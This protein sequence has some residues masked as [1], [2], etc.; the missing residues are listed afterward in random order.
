[1]GDAPA[2][3]AEAR[4]ARATKSDSSIHRK[5]FYRAKNPA[6]KLFF[7]VILPRKIPVSSYTIFIIS[8]GHT[9]KGRNISRTAGIPSLFYREFFAERNCSPLARKKPAAVTVPLLFLHI[10]GLFIGFSILASSHGPC[11]TDQP[12]MSYRWLKIS[13]AICFGS[14]GVMQRVKNVT[15]FS[16]PE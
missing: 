2:A 7:K 11:S 3:G 12:G 4:S 14:T 5:D 1:M 16:Q 8:A 6:L 15:R 9:D 10:R 13:P